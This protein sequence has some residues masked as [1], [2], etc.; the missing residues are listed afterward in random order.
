[1]KGKKTGGRKAGTPNKATAS[2]RESAQEFTGEALDTVVA[3]MR[4]PETPATT[5]LS[6][7]T[8]ILDRGYGKPRL[9]IEQRIIPVDPFP[10]AAVLD[11]IRRKGMDKAMQLEL[12]RRK[13]REELGINTAGLLAGSDEI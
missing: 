5:K 10:D 11:E 4:D 2:L 6:A 3:I 13:I 7:A 9:E 8:A 1:M 12:E